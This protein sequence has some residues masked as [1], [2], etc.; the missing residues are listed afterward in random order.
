[1]GATQVVSCDR[2]LGALGL[3]DLLWDVAGADT[4]RDM[5]G[6]CTRFSAGRGSGARLATTGMVEVPARQLDSV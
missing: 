1:M 4:S 6:Y 2:G 3:G 5:T